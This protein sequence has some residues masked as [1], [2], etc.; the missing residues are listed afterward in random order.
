VSFQVNGYPMY[1]RAAKGVTV[2]AA[3]TPQ[4]VTLPAV[5][6]VRPGARAE[7]ELGFRNVWNRDVT[8]GVV[9]LDDSNQ[10]VA[11]A[12]LPLA[13]GAAARQRLDFALPAGLEAGTRGYVL[14]LAVEGAD[15][16]E[17]LPLMVAVGE[18]V[19]RSRTPLAADGRP[20]RPAAAGTLVLEGIESIH[21]LVDD[22]G[23]PKWAGADDLS[24]KAQ[25]AHDDQGLSLRFEVRDQTHNPGEPGEKLWA[26]DSVQ[27]GIAADGKQTEVGFTEAGGGSGW[28]WV[29][30]EGARV[31]ALKTPVSARREGAATTY[32]AYVPFANLGFEYR[33]GMLVRMTFAVNEDDGKG[34]VRM[35]KWFDGIHPGKDLEKFGY[36]VLE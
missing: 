2:A 16:T 22:P 4:W 34:R 19:A 36:L 30:P 29:S 25:F 20:V 3:T 35:L 14:H 28:C 23:T 27:V 18:L 7:A 10:K 8:V 33:P 12:R 26:R 6:G 13:S 32:E 9:L 17:T 31:G 5:V 21:D 24:V 15:A 11:E 1:L